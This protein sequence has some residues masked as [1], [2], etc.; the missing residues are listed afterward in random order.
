MKTLKPFLT[1]TFILLTCFAKAQSLQAL[2]AALNSSN[3]TVQAIHGYPPSVDNG[4]CHW[5]PVTAIT[6]DGNDLTIVETWNSPYGQATTTLKGT[7]VKGSVNG[8]WSSSFSSGSWSY[9]FGQS[10]G[11][12]NKT[13]SMAQPFNEFYALKFRIVDKKNLKDGPYECN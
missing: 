2:Q 3:K 12:W 9:S 10:T 7:L 5:V 6:L 4:L 11:K 8:D 1:I 13:H